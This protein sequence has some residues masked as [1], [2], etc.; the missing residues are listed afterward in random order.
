[1]H[2]GC[3]CPTVRR[4]QW[5]VDCDVCSEVDR[6]GHTGA[7]CLFFSAD[8]GGPLTH[9]GVSMFVQDIESGQVPTTYHMS[10]CQ[11]H[12]AVGRDHVAQLQGTLVN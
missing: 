1:M 12:T 5:V 8:C 3:V 4:N 9:N 10:Y 7:V 2:Q 11:A 6:Y